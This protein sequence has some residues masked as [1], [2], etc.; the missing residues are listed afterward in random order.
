MGTIIKKNCFYKKTGIKGFTLMEV[1]V[2]M[3]ILTIIVVCF[4]FVYGWSFE[5]IFLMGD[6]SKVVA[7][8]QKTFE[9]LY[10]DI[11]DNNVELK[12]V[13]NKD[14]LYVYSATEPGNYYVEDNVTFTLE[15]EVVQGYKVTAV[16]FY[17]NGERNATVSTFI[18]QH[19]ATGG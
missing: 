7:T 5:N 14:D 6:K 9:R 19:S 15:D 8:A 18:P 16:V 4:T 10:I 17:R 11:N 2:A 3:A 1:L 13:D 12:P